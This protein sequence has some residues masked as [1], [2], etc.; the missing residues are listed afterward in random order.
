MSFL[1]NKFYKILK[2]K[3]SPLY[4]YVISFSES[5]FLPI[6]TDT[7]LIPMALANKDRAISLALYTT[8]F[9][10]LGGAIAYMIGFLLF[11]TV[12]IKIIENFD[13]IEKFQEFSLSINEY[14]YLFIFIAGFTPIPYKI[15]A[16][17]SGV[18]GI[19]F[20]VF[21]IF[22]LASRGLRFLSEA[23]LCRSLGNRA[24]NIIKKYFFVLTIILLVS[25]IGFIIIKKVIFN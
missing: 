15:A 21:I 3:R 8:L 2:D 24:E 19:S 7:F 11:D 20:P 13:L 9:S 12:G 5:I 6:P 14:G 23:I 22:S 17:A 1:S 25:L 10:V 4:L 18:S 16:I